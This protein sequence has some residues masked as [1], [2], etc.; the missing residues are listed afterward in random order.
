MVHSQTLGETVL[1]KRE[2][3]KKECVRRQLW[4][5]RQTTILSPRTT[6]TSWSVW[7]SGPGVSD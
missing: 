4:S 2:R 3:V 1:E 6:T 5:L 7:R